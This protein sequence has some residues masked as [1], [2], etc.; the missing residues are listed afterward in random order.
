[1]YKLLAEAIVFGV[2]VSSKFY[3]KCVITLHNGCMWSKESKN[4]ENSHS[5]CY[6]HH[7]QRI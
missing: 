5:K 6:K 2:T 3:T 7:W 4:T 1:M